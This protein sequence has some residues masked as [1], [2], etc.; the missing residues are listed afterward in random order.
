[1]R[2]SD[3][4]YELKVFGTAPKVMPLQDVGEL[5]KRFAELLGNVEGVHFAG[6]RKGSASMRAK[7]DDHAAADVNVQLTTVR[8][9]E[10]SAPK[11]IRINDYLRTRGWHGVVRNRDGA[12]LLTFPGAKGE[13]AEEELRTVQQMD[14]VVGTVIKIGGRDE[15]VPMTLE[16]SDGAF[17]DVTVRGRDLAKRLAQHLFGKDIRVSGLATWKRDAEGQWSCTNM[18]VGDFEEL[19]ETPL[20]LLFESLRDLPGNGWREFDDPIGEWKKLR[21]DD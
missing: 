15:T 7:V 1:M 20:S 3:W 2:S 11:V 10:E 17:L 14:S 16:T 8:L 5:A 4:S 19:Q 21:G 6:L 18:L 9:Q 12:V 13:K